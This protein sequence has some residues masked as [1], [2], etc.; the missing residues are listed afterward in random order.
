M[1]C[2]L[3]SPK[4]KREE[5]DLQGIF[6]EDIYGQRGILKNHAEIITQ[7]KDNS[8]V[9]LKK[10]EE[11]LKFRLGKNSFFKF[12]NNEGIILSQQ[13]LRAEEY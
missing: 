12:N 8:L 2:I 9:R 4:E 1:K 7:L 6:I 11:E 13:F 3:I 5:A 10:N